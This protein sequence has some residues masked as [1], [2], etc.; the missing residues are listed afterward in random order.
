MQ[1]MQSKANYSYWNLVQ[2]PDNPV[3][4]APLP[5]V[6]ISPEHSF[7]MFRQQPPQPQPQ[8]RPQP[9]SQVQPQLQPQQPQL[10]QPER[11]SPPTRLAPAKEVQKTKS[12]YQETPANLK[13]LTLPKQHSFAP[14]KLSAQNKVSQIPIKK[15]LKMEPAR[16][17]TTPKQLP[18]QQQPLYQPP[19]K[20][21]GN[22]GKVKGNP[23]KVKGNPGK[24][25][26]RSVKK[27][28]PPSRPMLSAKMAVALVQEKN[29]QELQQEQEKLKQKQQKQKELE[30]HQQRQQEQ[31]KQQ[32]EMPKCRMTVTSKTETRTVDEANRQREL[33]HRIPYKDVAR[34]EMLT[35]LLVDYDDLDDDDDDDEE[36]P[37]QVEAEKTQG[38]DSLIDAF[39]KSPS[40]FMDGAAL[41]E[42]ER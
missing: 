11:P 16:L 8:P 32:E 28:D 27:K 24:V 2:A 39:M 10:Q 37:E 18:L 5:G 1:Q 31:K 22:P 9:Q 17:P 3:R 34:G 20:A 19:Q 35:T 23:G 29:R 25:Q 36:E 15:P 4:S 7:N 33:T 42:M 38:N 13:L 6:G 26:V 30:Q 14:Q 21:K 41:D 12:S 40:N